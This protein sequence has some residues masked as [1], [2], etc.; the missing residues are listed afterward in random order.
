MVLGHGDYHYRHEPILYGYAPGRGRWGR[1]A[2]GWYGGNGQDS[3]LE[4][5]RPSASREHPTAK[6]VEL[7][8]RCLE[9]SSRRGDRVLDPFAGSG[10]TL[11]AA[12]VLERW[13]YGMELDPRYCDVIV[14][15]MERL[16]GHEATRIDHERPP[17]KKRPARAAGEET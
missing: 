9:N 6:P 11:V 12:C 5:P 7:I 1:G 3:V 17:A 4:V 8:R 14:D 16:T 2:R 10:S 13:G 15:R